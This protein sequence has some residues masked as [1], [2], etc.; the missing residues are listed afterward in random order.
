MKLLEKEFSGR[1]QLVKQ[2][3]GILVKTVDA[4]GSLSLKVAPLMI[5]ADVAC[6]V[7]VEGYYSDEDEPSDLQPKI[8]VL[9]HVKNG[10]L[11]EL[12]VYKDDG[13]PIA[14]RPRASSI[15]VE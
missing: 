13:S 2:L 1:S 6:T 3:E 5:P 10:F 4:E 11:A 12:E 8:H 7:P 14:K 15:I 9:I